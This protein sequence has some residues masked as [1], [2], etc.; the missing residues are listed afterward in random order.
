LVLSG[1]SRN[2]ENII[3]PL[4]LFANYSTRI[5]KKKSAIQKMTDFSP[6]HIF[7]ALF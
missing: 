1:R 2:R 6:V 5:N 7:F 4:P 3:Q